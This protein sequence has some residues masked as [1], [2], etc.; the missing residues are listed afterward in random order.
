MDMFNAFDNATIFL[1]VSLLTRTGLSQTSRGA[2][3]LGNDC[4]GVQLLTPFKLMLTIGKG[5][6]RL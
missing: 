6:P 3:G 4:G 1:W 5:V 2:G